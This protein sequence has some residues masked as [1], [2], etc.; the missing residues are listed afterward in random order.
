L[1]FEGN[2]F[3][4][5][6]SHLET[7]NHSVMKNIYKIL[8]LGCFLVTYHVQAKVITVSN[9][10]GDIAQHSTLGSALSEAEDGDIIYVSGSEHSYGDQNVSRRVTLVGSGHNPDNDNRFISTIEN[11]HFLEG[12]AG[13]VVIG[14]RIRQI[15]A[16]NQKGMIIKQNNI[17]GSGIELFENSSEWIIKENIVWSIEGTSNPTFEQKH[18]IT[19]NIILGFATSI[20]HS[21]F[22]NN[23]FTSIQGTLFSVARCD[24]NNNIFYRNGLNSAF[25]FDRVANCRFFNNIIFGPNNPTSLP[26]VSGNTG[27]DNIFAD[28]MF[29]AVEGNSFSY[30]DDYRLQPGSPGLG[31]GTLGSEIGLFGGQGFS[32]TGEPAI[33]QVSMFKILNPIVPQNGQ[34]NVRIEGRANK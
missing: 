13:S 16:N 17:F 18:I 5:A 23:V 9:R 19:N 11:L 8:V 27:Q 14:F 34:L 10:E 1:P 26:T 25:I 33:P 20:Y 22:E 4:F 32:L 12:S 2:V 7:F 31:G 6:V 3:L 24:F 29:V 15:L 30:S 28:P 21:L